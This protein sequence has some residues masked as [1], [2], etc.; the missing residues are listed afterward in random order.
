MYWLENTA[1]C[2]TEHPL[3]LRKKKKKKSHRAHKL[4]VLDLVRLHFTSINVFQC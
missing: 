4:H 2:L 3:P 1:R